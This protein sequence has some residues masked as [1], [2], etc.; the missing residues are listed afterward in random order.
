MALA[1]EMT[2]VALHA[3]GTEADGL[4]THSIVTTPKSFTDESSWQSTAISKN[5]TTGQT[6][7]NTDNSVRPTTASFIATSAAE[8][9]T[10]VGEAPFTT[11]RL[12]SLSTSN[13]DN[14]NSTGATIQTT[15]MKA[16]SVAVPTITNRDFDINCV[17]FNNNGNPTCAVRHDAST[18]YLH[19]PRSPWLLSY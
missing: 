2:T 11:N 10:S 7:T 13:G 1:E 16:S 12:S 14:V 5:E 18:T 3:V 15:N 17:T 9:D 6:V 19:L 8:H 4:T